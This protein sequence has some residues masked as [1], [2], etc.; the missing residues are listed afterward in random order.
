LDATA[1]DKIIERD[2]AVDG[3][4]GIPMA[5]YRISVVT[6]M[7]RGSGTDSNVYLSLVGKEGKI[8]E[9]RLA[10]SK[11][12]FETGQI[13]IFSLETFDLGEL[14]QAKIRHDNSGFGP[15]WY[16]DKIFIENETTHKRW[17]FICDNWLDKTEGDKKIERIL[18]PSSGNR[19]TY[20]LK[21]ET[22]NIN[23]AGTDANITAI[24]IGTNG[25]SDKWELKHSNRMNKF[26][27]G[28][29][30]NF[31]FD[32]KNLGDLKEFE[33][34]SDG[35]GVGADWNVEKVEVIDQATKELTLFKFQSWLKKNYIAAKVSDVIKSKKP[36][37]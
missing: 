14:T 2:L 22:G 11:D 17:V 19:T 18:A 26:E 7:K 29:I 30:D 23:N 5:L 27:K 4:P 25:K 36:F 28:Q 15:G 9:M 24:L 32:S 31:T 33:L 1:G 12:N 20:L 34:Y 37:E 3:K 16:L 10:N 8:D 35:A 13:D 21:I 6:G